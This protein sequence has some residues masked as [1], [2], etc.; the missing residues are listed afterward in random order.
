M[1]KRES[2]QTCT[3]VTLNTFSLK[4]PLLKSQPIIQMLA[5]MHFPTGLWQRVFI[6]TCC[7]LEKNV[8]PWH[9]C[10]L[11]LFDDCYKFISMFSHKCMWCCQ[12]C[13]L[14]GW[15]WYA[16]PSDSAVDKI[17]VR[18]WLLRQIFVR[19]LW[20]ISRRSI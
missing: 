19:F 5:S 4:C 8:F 12:L 17:C 14:P 6:L 11:Q 2:L 16:P 9:Q 18:Q 1:W 10:W 20:K 7:S 15:W 13:S 3:C